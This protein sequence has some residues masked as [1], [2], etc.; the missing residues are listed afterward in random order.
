MIWLRAE[1][2]KS[3]N[4][5]EKATLFFARFLGIAP[6]ESGNF[7]AA[8]LLMNFFGYIDGYPPFFFLVDESDG[9]REE[10]EKAMRFDTLPLVGRMALALD[11]SLDAY[12]ESAD[13]NPGT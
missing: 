5:P 2:G 6:F 9:V 7:R 1:S 3:L 11:R 4:P 13:M 8:H 12:L 10:I